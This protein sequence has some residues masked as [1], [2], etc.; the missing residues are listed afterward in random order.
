M[1]SPRQRA[2]PL[3]HATLAGDPANPSPQQQFFKKFLF[4]F[5]VA[6]FEYCSPMRLTLRELRAGLELA[7]EGRHRPQVLLNPTEEEVLAFL[8]VPCN[9]RGRTEGE[10][11]GP[12]LNGDIVCI[13]AVTSKTE[14]FYLR[15]DSEPGSGL[16]RLIP[17]KELKGKQEEPKLF[18]IHS[19]VVASKG[20][21]I[22]KNAGFLLEAAPMGQASGTFVCRD[23]TKNLADKLAAG[24]DA[25]AELARKY[26]PVALTVQAATR[27]LVN[28]VGSAFFKKEDHPGQGAAAAS[29]PEAVRS[30]F[31]QNLVADSGPDVPHGG[32]IFDL[33]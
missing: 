4:N 5:A 1:G 16:T 12:V 31:H 27:T 10:C 30:R 6:A 14:L 13:A 29:E 15:S 2:H 22:L 24:A 18:V 7:I 32:C 17:W 26:D 20:E 23:T 8:L 3:S 9:E 28:L 21:P 11:S 25:V 33:K 19:A